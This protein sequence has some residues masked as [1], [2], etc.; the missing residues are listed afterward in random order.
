MP[1]STPQNPLA[2]ARARSCDVYGCRGERKGGRAGK[3]PKQAAGGDIA[4]TSFS[5]EAPG[6]KEFW[7]RPTNFFRLR[8][9]WT[10]RPQWEPW[11]ILWPHNR[12]FGEAGSLVINGEVTFGGGTKDF[13]RWNV[14]DLDY[15]KSVEA[16]LATKLAEFKSQGT[17]EARARSMAF[18]PCLFPP[19]VRCC[20]LASAAGSMV[21]AT[22][23]EGRIA[24]RGCGPTKIM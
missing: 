11:Y 17:D 18:C 10:G 8:C 13:F 3:V 22:N 19:Y 12:N 6:E 15:I 7:M 1:A 24:R 14:P 2:L 5:V 4:S 9:K 23:K 16:A 21:S 20:R